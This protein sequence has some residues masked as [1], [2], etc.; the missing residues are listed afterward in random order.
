LVSYFKMASHD[1][2]TWILS[3]FYLIYETPKI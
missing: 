2:E 1:P 3:T